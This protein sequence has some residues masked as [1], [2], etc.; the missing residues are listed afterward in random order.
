M[1]GTIDGDEGI[2]DSKATAEHGPAFNKE[3]EAGGARAGHAWP[4]RNPAINQRFAFS[5][6]AMK[7]GRGPAV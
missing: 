3:G 5:F 2:L 4:K 6:R 7:K 1:P